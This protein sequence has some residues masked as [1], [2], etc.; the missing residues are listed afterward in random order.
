MYTWPRQCL[1]VKVKE[2]GKES[3]QDKIK[4]KCK[5]KCRVCV[6]QSDKEKDKGWFA[7][8]MFVFKLPFKYLDVFLD[9]F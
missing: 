7:N 8:K 1:Q 4:D 6:Y 9:S 3:C 2:K 5:G